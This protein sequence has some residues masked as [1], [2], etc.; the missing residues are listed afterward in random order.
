MQDGVQPS[1]KVW[2]PL[3]ALPEFLSVFLFACPGLVLSWNEEND[4]AVDEERGAGY[5]DNDVKK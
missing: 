4:T 3:Y 2:Y 5:D 1:E